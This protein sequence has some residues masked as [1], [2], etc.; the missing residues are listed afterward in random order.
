MTN[1]DVVARARSAISKG[2]IYG[3]GKGG[4]HP[5]DPHPWNAVKE[6]DCSGFASWCLGVSRMIGPKHPW[7]GK[8]HFEWIETTNC[9]EDAAQ[10]PDEAFTAVPWNAAQPG[11]LLVYG[12]RPATATSKK[13]QGH[14]GV[15][16]SI[17]HGGPQTV[18]HCAS[19]NKPDAI[20][21]TE[22]HLFA[23][24]GAIVARLTLLDQPPR[25]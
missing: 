19:S 23:A 10:G 17:G 21:E 24:R 11:D 20:Q 5:E 15:V 8:V 3:L 6:C 22:C 25:A 12:D 9:F 13:R 16:A 18:V 14:V 7:K 2:C 1:E 4:F